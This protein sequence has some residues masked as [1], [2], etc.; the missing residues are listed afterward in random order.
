[1]ANPYY[2]P[3]ENKTLDFLKLGLQLY[4]MKQ[5]GDLSR[6][7]MA[8]TEKENLMRGQERE[9]TDWYANENLLQ[10]RRKINIDEQRVGQMTRANQLKVNEQPHLGNWGTVK[11]TIAKKELE[12]L[13]VKKDF[14]LFQKLEEMAADPNVTNEAAFM[15]LKAEY[16]QVRNELRTMIAEDFVN[17]LEKDQNYI[18]SPEGMKQSAVLEILDTDETGDKYLSQYF[19][20]TMQSMKRRDA[21]AY[22]A[23]NP[24][25][26][27]QWA[28]REVQQGRMTQERLVGFLQSIKKKDVAWGEPTTDAQG[29]VIQ[30]S[31]QGKL[32]VVTRKPTDEVAWGPLQTDK[33]GN[34]FQRSNRGKIDII[35]KAEKPEMTQKEALGK[36]SQIHTALTRLGKG[37]VID[38]LVATLNPELSGLVGS[39]DPAALEAAKEALKI[40]LADV[41]K[42]IPA[43]M[44]VKMPEVKA[45]GGSLAAEYKSAEEVKAAFQS[46]KITKEKA[47]EL[48]QRN[49]G[50]K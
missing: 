19:G 23:E 49:F 6:E 42:Y 4:G 47:K 28:T 27:E 46:G 39:N 25:S 45:Q 3:H 30:R 26:P 14:Y 10:N 36:Q 15:T 18:K 44:R 48:L 17:K 11:A 32:D 37:G 34:Q 13:G 16:P 5:H 21:K 8:L 43:N 50:F 1:M 33:G 40:Q 2:I 31:S 9:Q 38:A 29:N 7:K 22:E 20:P 24:L 35:N 41:Q 12:K